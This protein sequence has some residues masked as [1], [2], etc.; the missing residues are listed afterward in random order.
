MG[1][2]L[3]TLAEVKTYAGL[4][5]PNQD[6]TI[7]Q[8]IPQVSEYVKTYCNRTFVDYVND[9]KIDI[10]N[11]GFPYIYLDETPTLVVQSVEFTRDY[12][13][14]YTTLVDLTNYVLDA[15][16]DR[17]QVLQATIFP[18]QINGYKITYTAGYE[19]LPLDLKLAV[20]DL[21]MYYLKSDM[22]VKSNASPGK[23]SVAVEY[24]T[25]AALPAHISR[26]LDFYIQELT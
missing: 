18:L 10:V 14:T 24:I 2:S 4:T 22:A 6:A 8:L 21:I 3:V 1:A 11:G 7:N 19:V 13:V 9:A 25:S 17:I 26:V 16:H 12:G 20:L 5:S 23:N 15:Q